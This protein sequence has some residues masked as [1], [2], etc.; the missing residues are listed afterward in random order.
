MKEP[1]EVLGVSRNATDE[2]IK[3]AYKELAKKYHP[4]NYANSPLAD[5]AEEK[6][7]EIN[8]AYDTVISKRKRKSSDNNRGYYTSGEFAD[9]RNLINQGRLEEAQELLDGIATDKR[10]AEWYFLNGAVLYRRGWYDDAYTS[11]ATACRM[12]PSNMEYRDALNRMARQRNGSF[13]TTGGYSTAYNSGGC[14]ACD[15]CQGLIC[16]DCCCECMGGDLIRCC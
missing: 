1:Y 7:K 15:V 12:D 8:E 3:A 2:E 6:M 10:S 4:D 9:I 16:A 11:Y 14:S 5:L 13:N